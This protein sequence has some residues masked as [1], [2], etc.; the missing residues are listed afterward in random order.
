MPQVLDTSLKVINTATE[1]SA[2]TNA[3]IYVDS[4]GYVQGLANPVKFQYLKS[5]T[6]QPKVTQVLQV[7]RFLVATGTANANYTVTVF[8]FNATSGV[9]IA[10]PITVNSGNSSDTT[11]IAG[12][13]VT[14]IN[15]IANKTF[16]ATN[17][18]ATVILTAVSPLTTPADDFAIFPNMIS[19]DAKLTIYA[20]D[21]SNSTVV[22]V[23]GIGY[24]SQ[25]IAQFSNPL[26]VPPPGGGF[27]DAAL[28]VSTNNYTTVKINDSINGIS[29]ILINEGAGA[30][31]D[32]V[33]VY[34][35]ITAIK[36][37]MRATFSARTSTPTA[38]ITVTTGAI[39]LAQ[40]GGL[41]SAFD[42]RANDYLLVGAAYATPEAPT[43]IKITTSDTAGI[44]SY[45][46]A[47]SAAV[48]R[49]VNWRVIPN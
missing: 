11:V 48:F 33:G 39:A 49:A 23:Q 13:L 27:T 10:T 14:A 43:R 1:A 5:T 37:G 46:V 3:D 9:F 18:T 41:F 36:A 20:C 42:L 25:L 16:L 38:A 26:A 21:G 45:I 47:V 8:T 32:L 34:G 4:N 15:G 6:I 19:S 29:I 40:T 24:G 22:G 12:L 17:S 30:P 31:N 35:T 2:T 28:L 7:S 44:G